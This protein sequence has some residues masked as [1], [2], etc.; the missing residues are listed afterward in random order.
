ME[1]SIFEYGSSDFA[2]I[3]EYG[4]NILEFFLKKIPL[5]CAFLREEGN[6]EKKNVYVSFVCKSPHFYE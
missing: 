2:T 3:I 5:S 4:C 6:F 1:G